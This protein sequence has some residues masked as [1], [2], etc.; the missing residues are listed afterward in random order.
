MHL[1]KPIKY[2]AC[3]L[4]SGCTTEAI[5][6][7]ILIF[8]R[9]VLSWKTGIDVAERVLSLDWV[10]V[11]AVVALR[12]LKASASVR[13]FGMISSHGGATAAYFVRFGLGFRQREYA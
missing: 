13:G 8:A 10:Y 11:K 1:S 2:N 6:Q 4:N 9:L 7:L 5:L 3:E 12:E